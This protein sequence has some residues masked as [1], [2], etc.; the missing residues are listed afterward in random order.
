MQAVGDSVEV[1]DLLAEREFG[2]ARAATERRVRAALDAVQQVWTDACDASDQLKR[3][4]ERALSTQDGDT[5]GYGELQRKQSQAAFR[6]Y[7]EVERL[8]IR[9]EQCVQ[10]LHEA[11]E[12]VQH[13]AQRYAEKGQSG[14]AEGGAAADTAPGPRPPVPYVSSSG[15]ARAELPPSTKPTRSPAARQRR[16]QRAAANRWL[17]AGGRSVVPRKIRQQS[18]GRRRASSESDMEC[19]A[20]R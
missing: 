6:H 1:G 3:A 11:Y 13:A 7:L 8:R 12:R 17:Q 16:R 5:V 18:A 15:M 2:R 10:N 14:A 20:G 9:Y 19:D 4:W